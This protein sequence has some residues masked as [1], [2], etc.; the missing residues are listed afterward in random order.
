VGFILVLACVFSQK[1]NSQIISWDFTSGN[2]PNTNLPGGTTV[3]SFNTGVTP[4]TTGCSTTNGYSSNGWNVGEYLQIVI[5]LSGYELTTI[6]FNVRSSP[7]GPANFKV[8]YSSTGA[9]GTF[10]DFPS[11]SFTSGNNV[12]EARS[13]DL[14]AINALDNNANTVIRLVFTGG[15]A[16]GSPATGD[17]LGSGTFRID[18]LIVNG[19]ALPCSGT[20]APGNTL[21]SVTS[22]SAGSSSTLSL[23]NATSGS[24]VTYQW[25]SSTTSATGPWTAIGTSVATLP[26][27]PA[28]VNTWYY[29]AV[30]CAGSTGNSIPVQVTINYCTPNFPT[31]TEPICNVTFNSISNISSCTTGGASYTN[32]T[33][34][35][36]TV[37]QGQ[38]Y[39]ISVSGNTNGAYTDYIVVYIDFNQN[40][41][42]TDAGE[43]FQIGTIT[44]CA[45]CA[46][47]GSITI[48]ANALI[49]QTRMRIVKRYS[50]YG[51]SCNSS[52]S[53]EAEDYTLNIVASNSP[54]ITVAGTLSSLTACF[55]SVFSSTSIN[56]SGTNLTGDIT[57][58]APTGFEVSLSSATGYSS[59][60]TLTQN[61]GSVTSV[62]VYFRIAASASLGSISGN[63]TLT[64]TG[65]STI[66]T[67]ING[68]V[69]ALPSVVTVS[70]AS[71]T[72]IPPS[73]TSLTASGGTISSAVSTTT[74]GTNNA[75]TP[76]GSS[77][78]PYRCATQAFSVR[79]QWVILASEL[80]SAGLQAGSQL[81]SITFTVSSTSGGTINNQTFR[82]AHTS[83]SD[84]TSTSFLTETFT[85]V[86]SNPS[87]FSPLVGAN[88][89]SFTSNFIWNGTSNIVIDECHYIFTGSVD[90]FSPI[91]ETFTTS[92]NSTN[93]YQNNT[94]TSVCT[95]PTG[96]LLTKRP[97]IKFNIGPVISPTWT[98]SPN[99]SDNTSVVTVGPSS[100]TTYYATATINGCSTT[101][102]AVVNVNSNTPSCPNASSIAP[103]STQAICQNATATQLTA[104]YTTGGVTGT[105]TVQYQWY[106][107]TT[108]SNTVSGATL[109]AGQTASTF[110]PPTSTIGTRYYF[111]LVYASDNGCA[112][113]NATQSLAS[114][115]VAVTVNG[116]ITWANT[117]SPTSGAICSNGTFD[118][119][120]Q[121]YIPGITEGASQGANVTA[122]LGYST[123][124]TDPST[125]TNWVNATHN[126]AVTGNND[127]YMGTLSGLAGNTYYYAFRYSYNGCAY[128][129]GGYSPPSAAS[130]S[131]TIN[132]GGGG[133]IIGSST[134]NGGGS[135]G[136]NSSNGSA[137]GLFNSSGGTAEAIR[138]FP[139]IIVGQ[140]VQ[141]DMDNGYVNSGGPTIGVGLQNASGQ[142]V[143]EI[144][145]A[146]GAAGY[147]VNGSLLS[148][149][150]PYTANGLRIT[151]TLLTATTYSA[152]I[153]ILNG[154][155]TYGPYTGTLQS[156]G[157]G[158][159]IT[160]FRAF[161]YNAGSGAN[162]DFFVNNIVTPSFYD[163]AAT[164][165]S[166]ANGTQSTTS[167]GG[168]WNSP[169]IYNGTLTVTTSP[170]TSNAGSNQTICEGTSATLAANSPSVGTGAWTITSGPN[171]NTN[172][173]TSTSANNPVFTPTTA[174]T[175]TL[176]WTISNGSCTSF[177]EVTINVTSG[178][179]NFV[180]TQF[181]GSAAICVGQSANVYGQVFEPGV[182][183]NDGQ[184]A[185]IEVQVGYNTSND[186]PNSW[187]PLNWS[188]ATYNTYVTGNNDEYLGTF[189]SALSA[190]TYYYAFRYRLNNCAWQY[191]GY[192]I[193]G[194]GTWDGTNNI[195][196]ILTIYSNTATSMT[197]SSIC[198]GVS[199]VAVTGSN[200]G[201]YELFVNGVSQG[202][203]SATNSWTI[204]GPLSTGNQ[205]CVRGYAATNLITMD[206]LFTEP[207]WSPA[208]VNSAGGATN[209]TQNRIN[210]LYVKNAF[211]YLNVGIAG[212]LVAGEDRK[213]LLFVDSKNGGHNSLST[214]T[215]RSGVTQNN[216]LKNL[217]G[218]MQFDPG[219]SADYAITIGVNVAGEGFLDLYDMTTNTNNYLGSTAINP[220]TI[221]YQ[222][223]TNAADYTK[224]YEIRIPINLFGTINSPM[225]FFTMLTNNPTDNSATNLSNQF[226]SAASSGE[227][228]YGDDPVN[229]G[230]AAPNPVSY[231]LESDCYTDTCRTVV[232]PTIPTFSPIASIC[233]GTPLS[234]LPTTSTN[235]ITG[236][237]SPALNNTATTTYTFTPTTGQ[238][239]GSTTLPISIFT[240]PSLIFLSPP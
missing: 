188:N 215:N 204:P 203:P 186:N 150:V 161:N 55:G 157:S 225:K 184:D 151:F 137:F 44:N 228:D 125:W 155:A 47:T 75:G 34:I 168:I 234:A 62:P 236:T 200:A 48:P 10:T 45:N 153:Q 173:L 160:R 194:G 120:G 41:L 37:T 178:I 93:S 164:Y 222:A 61:N 115:A 76:I 195:N 193:S 16:S 217:N 71:T 32:F 237:W 15:Q 223:N 187:N 38:S 142:N 6:S 202:V 134:T 133:A 235:G 210:A 207:F 42:F 72:I 12:C 233:S 53:G 213:I 214:W 229:F 166:I 19:T 14:S 112:Q 170:T 116:L 221:S 103:S 13:F 85:T 2:T 17:A 105:P 78:N 176:V 23:Q 68:T 43:T 77:G 50:Q 95:F 139:A 56:V 124:N 128:V 97:V 230:N 177:S 5:P 158:Q 104:S 58:N 226:L 130:N 26:A 84:F 206:G 199:N 107:N 119:Y 156:P 102:S 209:G 172:Q 82:I 197:P 201:S 24:G 63:I 74:I 154:G 171:T 198:A 7:S 232:A 182:T 20:P 138:N 183:P 83:T 101:S 239:A 73:T 18:D 21:A 121:V 106:Y 224:G 148:P 149:A 1:V 86:Y 122:Q 219:F 162:Y 179:L 132:A 152:T 180:N 30:T 39:P 167:V 131:W 99:T 57:V 67:A 100:T 111:C 174:G 147:S 33:N 220:T 135:S 54:N 192:S 9:S 227:G 240:N 28:S 143:W 208:L 87:N 29:C 159:S 113:T 79:N 146:G 216:G 108:N 69:N 141:F 211:G 88:T 4:G 175:Y 129:Y 66:T 212:R 123:T 46:V 190:G 40:G 22:L 64:S 110:T 3:L 181:P 144:F 238:C 126:P 127:E 49:G 36:T 191:G 114:N 109:V 118:V 185:N 163:N 27:T 92:F 59:S 218:G 90:S 145:F 205:V 52:S 165:S 8:Q 94:G 65:A 25:Y 51:L 11:G 91:I 189:G 89:H 80:T 169:T 117:Q 81:S 196:G 60:V 231:V 70:P 96:T 31:S 35:S 136:I 140:T 98:W